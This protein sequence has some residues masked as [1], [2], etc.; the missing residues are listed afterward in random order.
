MTVTHPAWPESALDRLAERMGILPE[1]RD[2]RGPQVR[3][4]A[5]TK[6]GL[7][8]AMG[9]PVGDEAEAAAAL[10]ALDR[11]EWLA[12]LSPIQVVRSDA[13]DPAVELILPADSGTIHWHLAREDG[14]N[15]TGEIAFDRLERLDGKHLDG[16]DL[17]R[18]RFTLEGL[19]LPWGY[20]RLTICPGGV[21]MT[22]VVTPG[23]C[24]LPE[25][26]AEGGRL[27][28]IAAQLYLLRS[29]NNW[30]IGDF[31][32]L[33]RLVELAA[34]RGAAIVG[35][36]PLHAMFPDDPEY[37][38][39]YSPASRLLLNILNIDITA[40]PELSECPEAWKLIASSAFQRRLLACRTARLVN[41][42]TVAELKFSVMETIFN[43]CHPDPATERGRA[44]AAF[45][46]DGGTALQQNCLFLA[47]RE[48]YAQTHA[49]DWHDWPE[50][51]RQPGSPAVL[52]FKTDNQHRL[53][54]LAW[55]QWIADDQLASAKAAAAQRGMAIGLYR[56]LAVGADRSGAETWTNPGAVVSDAHVGAPPDIL[57][58]QGQDW[59]LPPFHPVALR[60]ECYRSFIDLVRANMRHAG[61]LRIDHVMGLQRLWWVPAGKS[62]A[63]GGFVQ[64]PMEDLIGILALESH[65]HHCLVVGE[66]LGTVPD[67]FHE[68]MAD[69]YILS[70]RV[71]FFEQ[72]GATGAFHP[73]HDYPRRAL[74]VVGNH[75]LPTLRGWWRGRDL[76]LKRRLGMSTD[77]A[78]CEAQS[79]L[80]ERDRAE[81]LAAL[82]REALLPPGQEPDGETLTRAVHAFLARG[83]AMLAMA[84]LDDLTGEV[85]PV[86]VPTTST[87]HAN[88]RRRLSATLEQLEGSALF[89][90]VARMFNEIRGGDI[91]PGGFDG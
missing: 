84:Q 4:T 36:N 88:W 90:A 78:Q 11:A 30:G 70:Y 13:G 66:D 44:F 17:E 61:G 56:D 65:R 18:R 91:R 53:D 62:A 47:L 43:A 22:L 21:A 63:D 38:S 12:A 40:I 81:L 74:A 45:R 86:N 29:E 5:E 77:P 52:Q 59:G 80:R 24:W 1:Y 46:R 10:E 3:I 69:A 50:A 27:W 49:R 75:D 15:H 82:R 73:P 41:Y 72:D 57:N 71:L 6:R 60:Q 48:H 89:N 68:R 28:G 42:Q 23:R 85:D 31:S 79:R 64:Y 54:F 35:L 51:F 76:E 67:G 32:D 55:A 33:R 19:G 2:A 20:H 9:H 26:L 7:L 83:P 8:A 37:A 34:D 87:E 16:R 25:V 14:T 39:P 58:T